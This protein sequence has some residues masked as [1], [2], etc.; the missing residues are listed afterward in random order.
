MPVII[1]FIKELKFEGRIRL[2][3]NID[4]SLCNIVRLSQSAKQ[5]QSTL[6]YFCF[7]HCFVLYISCILVTRNVVVSKGP[8]Y[9][10]G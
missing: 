5:T 6:Y 3:S 1:A 8:F 4:S 10:L 7:Y 9:P 2:Y